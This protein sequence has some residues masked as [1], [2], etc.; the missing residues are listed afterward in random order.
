MDFAILAMTHN[1][2]KLMR[3]AKNELTEG[4]SSHLLRQYKP[5][6]ANKTLLELKNSNYTIAA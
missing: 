3:K 1:L 5:Y 6:S 2:R 4:R